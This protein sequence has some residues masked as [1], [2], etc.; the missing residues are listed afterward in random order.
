MVTK[1]RE[2]YIL[3]LAFF[4]APDTIKGVNI[5]WSLLGYRAM[6]TAFGGAFLCACRS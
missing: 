2:M 1:Y 3:F 4:T 5:K 6:S